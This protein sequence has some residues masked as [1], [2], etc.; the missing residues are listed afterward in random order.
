V[1]VKFLDVG[2]G[3][4]TLI[5]DHASRKALLI[6][7]PA[8][9]ED[10]VEKALDRYRAELDV[11]I[12]SHFDNDH[13]AGVVT[14]LETRSCRNLVTRVNVGRRTPT[15]EAQHRR[16]YARH[17][18]GLL[19]IESPR[20]GDTGGVGGLSGRI[21]WRVLSPDSSTDFSAYTARSRNRASLVLRVEIKPV[22]DDG[23][24]R[25]LMI[26]G[27]A[28]GTVWR[29]LISTGDDLTCYALLW[30]HHGARPGTSRKPLATELIA[31]CAPEIV[32][33]SAG[34][35]NT[36]GHPAQSTLDAVRES[37]ARLACT[38]VTQR[39]HSLADT[40]RLSCGGSVELHIDRSGG[41]EVA[42]SLDV[43]MKVIHGWDRPQ[44]T[45]VGPALSSTE[46]ATGRTGG[47]H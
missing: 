43:H 45:T 35:R 47:R 5:V 36:Y 23:I 38:Q 20:R 10:V 4:A 25:R 15:D 40:P 19:G 39:C 42:P 8:G 17:K 16:I 30:P 44:C 18:R 41:V 2:Q 37:R 46:S 1:T 7:C 33:V 34:S 21:R 9:H 32:I 28:D 14:L 12:I 13:S 29:R 11:A 27:D 6:D 26:A 24:T 3:D 22:D 31:T